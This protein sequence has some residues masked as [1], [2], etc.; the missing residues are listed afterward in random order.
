MKTGATEVTGAPCCTNCV[1]GG[2]CGFMTKWKLGKLFS[3]QFNIP[4][5][6]YLDLR[7]GTETIKS[8]ESHDVCFSERFILQSNREAE[9][10]RT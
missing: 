10:S 3:K 8:E 9:T 6:K 1:L 4:R 5:G 2:P 7:R